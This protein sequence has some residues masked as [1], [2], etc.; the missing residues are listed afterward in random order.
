MSPHALTA[1]QYGTG[2]LADLMPAVVRSL[3]V[4][5]LDR[6]LPE[7]A[8][9]GPLALAPT[10]RACVLLVDGLGD[11]L[12]RERAGHA[13]F[14]RGQLERTGTLTAGFPTTTATSMGSLGTGLPPGAHGLV[15]YEVLVPERDELLNELS[16]EP[17]VDPRRWQ[18]ETTMFQHAAAAGLD[19]VRIGPGFFDGS[20]LT[21]AA[22]RGGRFVA[23]DSLDDRVDAAIAALRASPRA[24]VYVYWGDVDK[25]GH[26]S[27]CGSWEWGE[28]LARVDLAVRR[29]VG[30]LPRGTTL[31]VTADHGMVD[32]PHHQRIDLAHDAELAKDVRHSGGEPRC[33]QL[34]CEPDRAESV[35]ATWT[36]RLGERADVLSRA[37][38]VDAGLFGVVASHVTERIGDVVVVCRPGLAVVDSRRMRP[39]LL[40]LV[41][42]HGALTPQESLVPLLTIDGPS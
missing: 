6:V 29:L 18:R 1:P 12:L 19:V 7:V 41:G 31:H 23:A 21:E 13:P 32:V 37:Q 25:V 17:A 9:S 35:Q 3:G 42:L 20:G 11:L 38:A 26:V 10:E 14:L 28:E 5:L 33:P 8:P 40:A 2:T 34:Y 27:G 15:G 4:D 39:A 30:G 24:L 36:E 22:L 16:W